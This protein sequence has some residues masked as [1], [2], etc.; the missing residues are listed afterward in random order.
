MPP[1][2][3]AILDDDAIH[4]NVLAGACESVRP[5]AAGLVQE[6]LLLFARPWDLDWSAV[7]APVELWYGTDDTLTPPHMGTWLAE[8]LP[9]V[10]L[11]VVPDQGHLVLWSQW[12]EILRSLSTPSPT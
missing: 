10:R 5:G 9:A 6:A 7:A 3:R 4:A 2:D 8:R 12:G 1:C 11:H